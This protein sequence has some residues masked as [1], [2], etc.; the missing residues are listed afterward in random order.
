MLSWCVLV[1]L[2][3]KP[4]WFS[5]NTW[6]LPFWENESQDLRCLPLGVPKVETLKKMSFLT[7]TLFTKRKIKFLTSTSALC[8]VFSPIVTVF[9]PISVVFCL[10]RLFFLFWLIFLLFRLFFLLLYYNCVGHRTG[11]DRGLCCLATYGR[12]KGL[13]AWAKYLF[14]TWNVCN[15]LG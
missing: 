12:W 6:H 9:S 8:T 1:R 15:S 3:T 4:T 11:G 5:T 14:N 10:F 13:H 2:G 7:F